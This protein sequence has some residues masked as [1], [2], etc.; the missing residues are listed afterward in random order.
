MNNKCMSRVF[1]VF[2]N[3]IPVNVESVRCSAMP[4]NIRWPGHQRDIDQTEICGMARFDFIGKTEVVIDT[5]RE[6]KTVKVRPLSREI[7][8]Q[9]DDRRIRFTID[10]PGFFSVELDDYHCNLHLFADEPVDYTEILREKNVLKFGPGEH[11]AGV[12]ELKSGD[13]VYL[14]SKAVVYGRIIAKDADDIAIVGRGIL[15]GSRVKEEPIAISPELAAE[16]RRK[17]FAITNV[18]RYNAIKLEFCDRVTIDGIVIRDSPLYNIRPICCRDISIRHVK[19]IGSW[20]YNTDGIDMHNCERVRLSDCF[21]RTFDDSICIKGFDYGMNEADMLHDGYRH[22]VFRD[23]VIERC[24][25]WC[26]W[27]RQLEF[28]AETRAEEITDIHF[29][30]CDLIHGIMTA[31]ELQ[32]CDYADIHDVSFDNIRIEMDECHRPVVFSETASA[33]PAEETE[34]QRYAFASV[35][36]VVPEYSKEGNRRGKNRNILLR[37]ISINAPFFPAFGLQDFDAEHCTTGIEVNNI[38]LN[39]MDV[40]E[41]VR[42]KLAR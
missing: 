39:G 19:I 18:R 15:D 29:R 37:D 27:G 11:E 25:V 30:D 36:H 21:L 17:G 8:P 10:R 16:Q 40:T 35:I 26:D 34:Y 22:D 13:A 23:T 28:G 7:V 5:D 31:C 4:V 38:R 32:N 12:I 20:R 42:A 6:F 9:I 14:D 33:C 3:G 41:E 24:T 2:V 1:S